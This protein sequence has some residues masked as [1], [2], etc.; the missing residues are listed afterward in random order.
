[1]RI[2]LK[3]ARL[4]NPT[5]M[6]L[7]CYSMCSNVI[8]LTY[9]NIKKYILSYVVRLCTRIVRPAIFTPED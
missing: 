4:N 6:T 5:V 7:S 3:N 9:D 8:V 1:M 2:F